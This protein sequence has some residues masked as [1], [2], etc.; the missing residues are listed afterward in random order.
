MGNGT[1]RIKF[2][3]VT[4]KYSVFFT[5]ASYLVFGPWTNTG[6]CSVTSLCVAVTTQVRSFSLMEEQV[7]T[8]RVD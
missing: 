7:K 2:V 5:T 3:P 4:F 1:V 6:P 8:F